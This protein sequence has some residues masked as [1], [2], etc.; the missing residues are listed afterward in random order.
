MTRVRR[1]LFL[2]AAFTLLALCAVSAQ[3]SISVVKVDA[4]RVGDAIVFEMH[5]TGPGDFKLDRLTEPGAITAWSDQFSLDSGFTESPLDLGD[6][7]TGTIVSSAAMFSEPWRSGLRVYLGPEADRKHA[8]LTN[9]ARRVVITVPLVG[10]APGP[11]AADAAA[12]PDKLDGGEELAVDELSVAD[13]TAAQDTAAIVA[14]AASHAKVPDAPAAAEATPVEP[15]VQ[16]STDAQDATEVQSATGGSFYVPRAD[17]ADVNYQFPP[18]SELAG[19]P[20]EGQGASSDGEAPSADDVSKMLEGI[21]KGQENQASSGPKAGGTTGA[22]STPGNS[23]MSGQYQAPAQVS[24]NDGKGALS[25]ITI[26]L[27]EIINTPLDQAITL[28]VAPTD[29]NVIVDSSVRDNSVSLSFKDKQTDLKSALDLITKVY[30]LEYVVKANTI[31]VAAKDKM[32]GNLMAYDSQLFVLS[33]ADPQSVKDILINTALLQ[34][35]QVEIYA[36]ETTYPSVN[37]STLLST[38]SDQGSQ[39]VKP[40]ESNL[41]STPRNAL[42]VKALPEDMKQIA[43]VIY[44]LDRKPKVIELEVRVCE[45]NTTALKNLGISASTSASATWSESTDGTLE[46]FTSGS[47][48][49]SP[50]SFLATLNAEIQN[51]SVDMLA[52]PTLSTVEGKQAIYFAGEQIPY[53]SQVTQAATGQSQVQVSFLNVGITLN[54]KPRLDSDGK[55]TIDVNPIVSSLLEFRMVG[56]Q[57]EAPRTSNRQAATTVRVSNGEPFVLA[58]LITD[59]E[60]TSITKIPILGDLPMVGKLFRDKNKTGSRTE[61]IIVVTPVVHN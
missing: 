35:D 60:R 22:F 47:F 7:S 39:Q 26:D 57:V 48:S 54:F 46:A 27:F 25:D 11:A 56:G 52:Q 38:T 55:L 36:G 37:D 13:D 43:A 51:G 4:A 23:M 31:V 34:E 1:G 16:A 12:E 5:T 59:T 19:T 29:Y 40:I 30:G 33:Y 45:A 9:E 24:V 8:T 14:D 6:V 10:A 49:R 61:I 32:A 2:G 53:V 58:G 18:V 21:L 20:D 41:S 17:Q 44:Q 42:L 50:L 28:L 15:E 3:A